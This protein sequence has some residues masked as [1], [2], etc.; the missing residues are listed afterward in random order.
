MVAEWMKQV[1]DAPVEKKNNDD[2][3]YNSFFWN[4]H[5]WF[6][7]GRH[8]TYNDLWVSHYYQ[9][10]SGVYVLLGFAFFI[11]PLVTSITMYFCR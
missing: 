7:G 6:G 5:K 1:K 4:L 8:D 2:G 9:H 3:R 10:Q 11:V